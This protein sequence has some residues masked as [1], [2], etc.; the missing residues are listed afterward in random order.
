MVSILRLVRNYSVKNIIISTC[1]NM[2]WDIKVEY[3]NLFDTCEIIWSGRK[4][5]SIQRSSNLNLN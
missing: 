3:K 5:L 4:L 1:I 2:K